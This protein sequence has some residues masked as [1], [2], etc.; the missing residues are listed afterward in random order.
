MRKIWLYIFDYKYY[1]FQK[2]DNDLHDNSNGYCFKE[3]Y[4]QKRKTKKE[5]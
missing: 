5:S 1:N 2:L 4:G 3:Y